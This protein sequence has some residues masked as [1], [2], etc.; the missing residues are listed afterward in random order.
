MKL[1]GTV[2]TSTVKDMSEEDIAALY[3]AGA[4]SKAQAGASRG[5]F[6]GRGGRGGGRGRGGGS[7]RG[8]GAAFVQN[9]E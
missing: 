7:G 1:P 9:T 4:E 3:K 8:R 2:D 5:G 6:R